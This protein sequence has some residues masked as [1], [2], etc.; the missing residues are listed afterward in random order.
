MTAPAAP[1][2]VHRHNARVARSRLL[3]VLIAGTALLLV[4][5]T[6]ASAA[7]ETLVQDD[8]SLIHRTN[9]QVRGSMQK[10]R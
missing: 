8:A 2:R 6:S 5:A 10:L 3:A 7:L 9:D 1:P 4:P